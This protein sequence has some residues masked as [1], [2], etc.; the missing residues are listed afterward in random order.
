[1]YADFYTQ[2]PV[3]MAEF[4]DRP[5]TPPPAEEQYHGFFPGRYTTAYLEAYIDNHTYAGQTIRD[6]IIFSSTVDRVVKTSPSSSSPSTTGKEKEEEEEEE[7]SSS[8]AAQWTITYNT[9]HQIQTSKLIDATGMTSQPQIPNLPGSSAFQGKTLHHKSFGQQQQPLLLKEEEEEDPSSV[10]RHIC[11]VGGAKSAADVAYACAKAPAA[12]AAGRRE[13]HWV[14]REHGNGPCAFFAAPA[15]SER[16]ANSNEGFY[17][18]FLAAFLPNRFATR[19]G[20]L[21][22]VLQGTGLG[23]WYVQRLWDGF[24]KGLRAFHDYQ[25][26]EGKEMGSGVA[27]HPDFLS[28]IAKNVHV[29]RRNISHLSEDSITLEPRSDG[30]SGAEK[31]LTIPVD[32]LVYCTGWSANSALFPP[33]EAGGMGL[34]VP[35]KD[36]DPQTQA[37]WQQLED[38]ADPLIL[39]QFPMLKYPPAYRKLEPTETP[40]RLY[41]AMAPPA[42]DT[43][44]IVFLGKMVVG[45]NFRTAEAQALWAVAYLDGRIRDLPTCMRREQEVAETV[46]W[47]RRRYLNKGE[48]GS[49]FYYDVVDY[50]D[51]LY[52]HLGLWSHRQKGFVGNLME[53]CFAADLRAMGDE[54]KQKYRI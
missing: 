49:W 21:K 53:P 42:D 25:R 22:W 24:D 43:H 41:K 48:L 26:E 40:F 47:D 18:R 14:I 33:H 32:V 52:E 6:R 13:I 11:I 2:T 35:L 36:A 38:A 50:A 7:S 20:W 44:S 4:S 31:P 39:A 15:M 10:R 37:H 5:M 29:H 1:M 30:S 8:S 17:N 28:I 46:A 23:R 27:N 12:A 54:Y 16:Y 19:W 9:T 34:S 3:K 45:N 51:M